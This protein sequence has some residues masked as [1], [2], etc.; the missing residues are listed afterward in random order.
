MK[1]WVCLQLTNHQ[2]EEVFL[3]EE[4][5]YKNMQKRYKMHAPT[6][7]RFFGTLIAFSTN[8][9]NI[10]L[11]NNIEIKKKK[12]IIFNC[13]NGIIRFY[14]FLYIFPILMEF[15]YSHNFAENITIIFKFVFYKEH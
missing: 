8:I 10:Q 9:V 11:L 5:G 6:L 15:F 14:Y 7:I 3:E 13:F 4:I 12:S 2:P 1:E